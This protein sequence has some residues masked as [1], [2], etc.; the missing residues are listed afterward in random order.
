M[1][2]ASLALGFS[3]LI[4]IQ[5]SAGESWSS[6]AL[7][8]TGV[9]TEP[10]AA[11]GAN[12]P[13]LTAGVNGLNTAFAVVSARP[14]VRSVITTQ[15]VNRLFVVPSRDVAGFESLRSDSSIGSTDV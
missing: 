15:Y 2:C 14:V 3:W 4:T 9:D 10:F 11:T 1:S 6:G 13:V 8:L 12:M 7:T 5:P